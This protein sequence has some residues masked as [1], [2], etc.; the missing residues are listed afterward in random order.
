MN[1]ECFSKW[2]NL[3][4]HRVIQT[5]SSY[6]FEAGPGAFQA[7]PFHWLI[8]PSENELR[9]LLIKNK[10]AALRYSTPLDA[11]EGKISYHIVKSKPYSL[12]DMKSKSRKAIIHGLSKCKVEQI[13]MSCL[14]QSGWD[15]QL[16]TLIRQQRTRSMGKKAWTKMC[17]AA[18]GIPGFEA[19]GA[20]VDG[21]LAASLL[22]VRIDDT[23]NFLYLL[24]QQKYFDLHV[25]HILYYSVAHE[26][27]QRDAI[28]SIFFTVQS[29][30]APAS[31]DEFKFRIGLEP[32][33][34]R[35][36]VLFHPLLKPFANKFSH[37]FLF[38][39]LR[40]IPNEQILAKG[41]GLL[42]FYLEGRL[43][44]NIQKLPPCLDKHP[45]NQSE[46][47]T[48]AYFRKSFPYN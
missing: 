43:P 7:F 17:L 33:P 9:E 34:V 14:A 26:M 45:Q 15:L 46:E 48:G 29:L 35:Q 42:H 8:S 6:W 41:E 10:I 18:E 19:W 28:N 13:S 5:K 30:D 2:H 47:L 12:D 4:G 20:V 37:K 44:P 11:P 39:L 22:A 25:N 32:K 27:L 21:E 23:W 36:R 24:S 38:F 1:A 16:N 31:V 40:F 3:Q